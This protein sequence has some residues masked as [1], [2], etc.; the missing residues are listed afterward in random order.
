MLEIESVC[1]EL[2][3]VTADSCRYTFF[4]DIDSSPHA[5]VFTEDE[6]LF[7]LSD[8]ISNIDKLIEG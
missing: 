7:D 4:A 8:R 5:D 1:L 6:V 2:S 3:F